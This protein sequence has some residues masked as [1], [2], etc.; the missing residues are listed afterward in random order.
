MDLVE[1]TTGWKGAA[2]QCEAHVKY[3]DLW[4]AHMRQLNLFGLP[5]IEEDFLTWARSVGAVRRVHWCRSMR[6]VTRAESRGT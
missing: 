2:C 1:V 4:I 6:D 3:W 5:S